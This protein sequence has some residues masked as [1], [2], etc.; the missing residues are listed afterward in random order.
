VALLSIVAFYYIRIFTDGYTHNHNPSRGLYPRRQG[1]PYYR[2]GVKP[3]D[4]AY[5]SGG[6]VILGAKILGIDIP[7]RF[8][9][10][11][12]I[13]RLSADCEREGYSFYFLGGPEGIAAKAADKLRERYPNLKIVGA[14]NGYFFKQGPENE[15]VIREIN[16]ACPDILLV[17]FGMPLQE[18]WLADNWGSIRAHAALPVGALFEFISGSVRRAPRWMSDNGLEWLFRLMLEPRRMFV[19]YVI[20]NPLFIFRVIRQRLTGR[21]VSVS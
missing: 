16:D 7:Q 19:R 20:G 2:K 3:R 15:E 1:N 13:W 21:K 12:W 5:D 17:G 14:R 18:R 9:P 6:K 4:W 10:A 8:T 11:D